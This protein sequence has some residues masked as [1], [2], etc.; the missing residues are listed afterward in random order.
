MKM[1][2]VLCELSKT[3]KCSDNICR[4]FG[5]HGFIKEKCENYKE[6]ID[7]CSLGIETICIEKEKK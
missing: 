2:V 1:K 6:K 7:G 4:H 3:P 5:P